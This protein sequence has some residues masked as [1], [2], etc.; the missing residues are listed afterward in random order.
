MY[1]PD[2]RSDRYSERGASLLEIADLVVVVGDRLAERPRLGPDPVDPVVGDRARALVRIGHGPEVVPRIV[3]VG[4][5]AGQGFGDECQAP[6]RIAVRRDRAMHQD[7]RP[8]EGRFKIQDLTVFFL[9]LF[10]LWKLPQLPTK[11][12]RRIKCRTQ[13]PDA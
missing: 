1:P 4:G 7:P 8:P 5:D 2:F 13:T 10:F 3:G 12:P 11:S 9:P 6:E